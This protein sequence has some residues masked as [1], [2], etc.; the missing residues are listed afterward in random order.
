MENGNTKN[1]EPVQPKSL[2]VQNLASFKD[3]EK[4]APLD[5]KALEEMRQNI[6][7]SKVKWLIKLYLQELPSYLKALQEGILSQDGEV[8]FS[9]AHKLKGASA[10]LGVRHV[11]TLCRQLEEFRHEGHFDE[12]NEQ[13]AEMK[14][15]MELAQ[16]ALKEQ[17]SVIR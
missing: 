9:A 11:V 1:L 12:A 5:L 2:E 10:I 6:N 7:H 17:L 3:T 15:Q 8:L 14:I 16:Q 4:D 13:L